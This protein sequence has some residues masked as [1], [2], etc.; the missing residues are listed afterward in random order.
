MPKPSLSDRLAP[1]GKSAVALRV[2]VNSPGFL[3][4]GFRCRRRV[5]DIPNNIRALDPTA[6]GCDECASCVSGSAF[7]CSVRSSIGASFDVVGGGEEPFARR[8][9]RILGFSPLASSVRLCIDLDAADLCY[10]L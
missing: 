4:V 2:A 10:D 9:A 3:R 1:S 8:S 6:G 7:V 5:R